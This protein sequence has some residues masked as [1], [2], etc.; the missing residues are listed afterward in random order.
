MLF[1]ESWPMATSYSASSVFCPVL[2]HYIT[3]VRG[4]L[5]PPPGRR[6]DT[7]VTPAFS[8][9][10]KCI[11]LLFLQSDQLMESGRCF[12]H[13]ILGR[14]V[15]TPEDDATLSVVPSSHP[16]QMPLCHYCHTWA[17]GGAAPKWL[18]GNISGNSRKTSG[19][20]SLERSL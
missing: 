2:L 16:T 7:G 4:S 20:P 8:S 13:R 10:G 12:W 5:G 14:G 9:P 1:T 15:V 17:D 11:D 19:T 6:A 18:K 3:G